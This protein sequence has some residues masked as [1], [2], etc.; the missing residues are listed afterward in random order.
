MALNFPDSPSVND[1]FT[2]SNSR[3]IWNGTSWVRQ[4]TPGTQG[5][6]GAQGAQGVQGSQGTTGPQ[7]AQG[8]QGVQGAQGDVGAQ[9]VQGAQGSTGVQGTVGA[10]GSTG[11][12]GAQGSVGAQ[13]STGAQGATGAQGSVGAQGSTGAQ[14]AQGTAGTS[15]SQGTIGAQGAQGAQ[16][17]QGAVGAQGAQGATGA[18]GSVGAQGTAGAQGAQGP[19]NLSGSV[20]I[21]SLGVGTP[22]SGTTGEIRATNN[23]TAFY[24]SDINLKTNIKPIDDPINKLLE[25]SGVNF[26]WKDEY[27]TQKGGEDGYFVRKNDV[28]VIAQEIEKVLPE[29]VVTRDDGYKAVRYELIIPLLIEAIKEQQKQIDKLKKDK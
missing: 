29:A 23:V 26:D 27:I 7:G 5:A 8:Y 14:G 13:G 4:G 19:S 11:A 9:G 2:S 24:S 10:Q 1:I 15:G 16:G 21:D 3:W 17:R 18:Q 28:G 12:Q 20:Q 6:Q 25:I 22:A